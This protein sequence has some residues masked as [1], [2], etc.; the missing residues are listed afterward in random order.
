MP[1][2]HPNH[3]R[4][5][6]VNLHHTQNSIPR[7]ARNCIGL[8][9]RHLLTL[10]P[11][12]VGASNL[13]CGPP[14]PCHPDHLG[15]TFTVTLVKRVYSSCEPAQPD[16]LIGQSFTVR[17]DETISPDTGSCRCGTG[18]IVSSPDVT[19]WSNPR[20]PNGGCSGD[21]YNADVDVSRGDC[22]ST[23][24]IALYGDVTGS[25]DPDHTGASL[26]Y[27]DT[28]CSC[29]GHFNVLVREVP[30]AQ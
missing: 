21:L 17:I 9:S 20:A 14:E 18:A 29:G 2:T 22:S 8:A 30:G 5:T 3:D 25:S 1:K 13:R 10:L 26:T 24:R 12:L 7:S 16:E 4:L 15:K 19:N 23:A 27:G 11:L 28:T 6:T